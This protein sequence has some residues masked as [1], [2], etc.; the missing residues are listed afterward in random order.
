[1][2]DHVILA[3]VAAGL[4]GDERHG[5]ATGVFQPVWLAKRDVD[6][7]ALTDQAGAG[8]E[9]DL[10]RAFDDNPVFGAVEVGLQRGG[11]AGGKAEG[12]D[13]EAGTLSE[14]CSGQDGLSGGEGSGGF[15]KAC[16]VRSVHD[17]SFLS[18]AGQ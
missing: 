4:H 16:R 9:R 2:A 10:C 1:M 7:L 11:L 14:N 12:A 3:E 6:G 15:G 8:A 17:L 5:Q 13:A 18:H